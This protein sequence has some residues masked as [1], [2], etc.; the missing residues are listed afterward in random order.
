MATK[1]QIELS[2][3]IKKVH[4]DLRAESNKLGPDIAWE[5]HLTN[6]KKLEKYAK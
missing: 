3:F 4:Q 1:E 5:N 2:D 6:S